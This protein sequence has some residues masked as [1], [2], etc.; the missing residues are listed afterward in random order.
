GGVPSSD[1]IGGRS[2]LAIPPNQ[3][4]RLQ[5]RIVGVRR[6]KNFDNSCPFRPESRPVFVANCNYRNRGA[7]SY[8]RDGPAPASLT[9]KLNPQ[10][11]SGYKLERGRNS[12]TVFV[13]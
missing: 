2:T 3:P 12:Q 5:R 4:R 7:R 11:S 13:E 8:D 1:L 9:R 6:A 10:R